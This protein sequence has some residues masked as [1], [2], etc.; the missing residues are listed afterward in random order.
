M[1]KYVPEVPLLSDAATLRSLLSEALTERCNTTAVRGTGLVPGST[2]PVQISPTPALVDVRKMRPSHQ[3]RTPHRSVSHWFLAFSPMG[4]S[5]T[6]RGC[7]L[8]LY[9]HRYLSQAPSL[10]M[11]MMMSPMTKKT[12]DD[13]DLY[14][15]LVS[16]LLPRLNRVEER[17]Q[18][19]A[20]LAH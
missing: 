6:A 7:R 3:Y 8:S 12:R 2:L 16:I 10:L 19:M 4:A 11:L 20:A 9:R 15:G 14:F 18:V 17:Q 5:K 13:I 1:R